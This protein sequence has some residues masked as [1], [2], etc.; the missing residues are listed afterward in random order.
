MASPFAEALT[1]SLIS[2]LDPMNA[3][4]KQF[5]GQQISRADLELDEAKLVTMQR[6]QKLIDEAKANGSDGNVID[7]Y[8]RMLMKYTS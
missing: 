2:G 1:Q 8:Q 6:L 5:A 3:V 4:V 7:A